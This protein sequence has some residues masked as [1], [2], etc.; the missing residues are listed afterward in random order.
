MIRLAD[1]G[2]SYQKGDA[3]PVHALR[4]IDLELGQGEMAAVV[5]PSGSGKSTLMNVLGLLD[6]PDQGCYQ[7]EG[8]DVSGRSGDE[9]AALRNRKIGFVFQSFYLLPRA[10]AAE[11]VE[12]PLLYRDR[13]QMRRHALRALEEVGLGDRADHRPGELSG[14][15]RQ[16]VAIARALV[17]DPQLILADEPTGN[18][19]SA[20]SESILSLFLELHRRGRTVLVVTH[21]EEVARCAERRI[22]IVDGRIVSDQRTD[23]RI[24]TGAN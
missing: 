20:V 11:N 5:G 8:Q 4:Q 3:P 10:T 17:N 1:V 24:P 21:D 18:L 15:Q 16:R 2:K 12:L 9:L 22:H 13:S 19:D 14:G 6:R 23:T 7:L